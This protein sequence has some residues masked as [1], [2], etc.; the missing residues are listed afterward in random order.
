MSWRSQARSPLTL[1]FKTSG[2]SSRISALCAHLFRKL[3]HSGDM[4]RRTLFNPFFVAVRSFFQMRKELLIRESL[5]TLLD[6]GFHAL[7]YPEKLATGLKE[8]VFVEQTIIEQGTGLI[9]IAE[10]HHGVRACFRSR[11]RDAHGVVQIVC[12]V[13]LEKPITRLPQSGFAAHFVDLQMELCLFMRGFRFHGLFVS[14]LVAL[15]IFAF[16]AGLPHGLEPPGTGA[17]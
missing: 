2:R 11:C 3:A 9:P 6:T 16:E 10:H 15:W 13:V 17:S 1:E 12:E 14:F 4:P 7:P 5:P 8:Q